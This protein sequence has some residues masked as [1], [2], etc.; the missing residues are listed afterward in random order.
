MADEAEFVVCDQTISAAF[1]RGKANCTLFFDKKEKAR[2]KVKALWR[3]FRG[4]LVG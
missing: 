4:G 1:P 3:R 2:A